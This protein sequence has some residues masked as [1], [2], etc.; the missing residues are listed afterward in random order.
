MSER[1]SYEE[2]ARL[3]IRVCRVVEAERIAGRDRLMKLVVDVG[4]ELRTVVAGGAEYY[5]PEQLKG[6]LMVIVANLRPRTI[7]GVESNGMLLA[8]DVGGRPVWLTVQEE[9][10]PGTKVR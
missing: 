8:A 4:G 10:P 6:K 5:A 3:D 1:V 9:V 2:F 7:A